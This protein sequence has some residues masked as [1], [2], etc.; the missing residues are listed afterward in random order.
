MKFNLLFLF[1]TLI[2][3]SSCSKGSSVEAELKAKLGE[4]IY[5]PSNSVAHILMPD[6]FS[7]QNSY[8]EGEVLFAPYYA[9]RVSIVKQS[10]EY[11]LTSQNHTNPE[12][13]FEMKVYQDSFRLFEGSNYTVYEKQ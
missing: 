6:C 3:I 1:T 11:I 10:G 4:G 8:A 5:K 12:R 2:L 9:D 13:D 7:L